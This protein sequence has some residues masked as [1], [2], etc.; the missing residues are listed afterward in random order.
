[1]PLNT[2]L[3]SEGRKASNIRRL[4]IW[5]LIVQ[6]TGTLLWWVILLLYPAARA[7]FMALGAPD[8][9][10]FAFAPADVTFY[11]VGSLAV[12]WGL[13]RRK[14]WAWPLLCVHSGAIVYS[15]LYGLGLLLFSGGGGGA[16]MMLPSMIIEPAFVWLLRPDRRN[17]AG[18]PE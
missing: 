15:A 6:A 2:Q 13:T 4:A 12:A 11:I 18:A 8:S 14:S 3:Q 5:F 16:L 9:T 10:L 7:P 1:L 17:D